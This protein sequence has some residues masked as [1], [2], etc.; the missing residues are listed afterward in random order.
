[1]FNPTYEAFPLGAL[2]GEINGYS[3]SASS[4]RKPTQVA[5]SAR[6]MVSRARR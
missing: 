4:R 5:L 2:C 1:M 3:R 6:E